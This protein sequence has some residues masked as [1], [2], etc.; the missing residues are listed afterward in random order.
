M[1]D[2]MKEDL[3]NSNFYKYRNYHRLWGSI[4]S[5]PFVIT[6]VFILFLS[7]LLVLI[8]FKQ[9]SKELTAV[10][11]VREQPEMIKINVPHPNNYY[12]RGYREL[13]YLIKAGDN[14]ADIFNGINNNN[15]SQT[16]AIL[17]QITKYFNVRKVQVGQEIE[18]KYIPKIVESTERGTNGI[19]EEVVIDEVKIRLDSLNQLIVNRDHNG[20]YMVRKTEVNL[21]R[22]LVKNGGVIENGLYI[23]GVDA[24]IPPG[25]MLEVI[26]VYGFDVDFQRDIHKGD[27]YE[28]LYE[29]F[30]DEKGKLVKYGEILYAALRLRNHEFKIYLFQ[31]EDGKEYYDE[32]GHTVRKSLL[33]TPVNGARI[34][35]SYGARK[36]PILGYTRMHQG[37]DFAVPMGTPIFA[38]GSGTVTVRKYWGGFGNYVRIRHNKDYETEYGHMSRFHPQVVVGTRVRQGQ[39][40]GYVGSTGLSTGPHVHLG[41]IYKG[42]RINP[43]RV[44]S[45][46]EVK[47]T[48][49]K[50]AKFGVERDKINTY[51]K[52]TPNQNKKY[53]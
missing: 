25:L 30:Y 53:Q 17:Q 31:S 37:I 40:I 11:P 33:K 24:G 42:K 49:K 10:L 44:K 45:V 32:K 34:S 1:P 15:N 36:H 20:Q 6:V 29:A 9:N 35:S 52:N 16:F 28:M 13:R 21:N 27:S 51:L 5:I 41:V 12:N 47:L 23:D 14:L 8:K 48:G 50:L 19:S 39:V 38:A 18:I 2:W 43:S 26:K 7:L 46:S 4:T 22:Y 3:K